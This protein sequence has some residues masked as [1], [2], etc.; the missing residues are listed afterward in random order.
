MIKKLTQRE[1][2]EAQREHAVARGRDAA[3]LVPAPAPDRLLEFGECARR[4]NAS[5]RTWQRLVLAGVGPP[6]VIIS[7]SR[8]GVL[9]SDFVAWIRSRRVGPGIAKPRPRGRPRKYP[10][11]AAA[12]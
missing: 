6:V 1:R 11:A 5:V 8:R 2:R 12:E 7:N 3:G 9:E 4:I 10:I